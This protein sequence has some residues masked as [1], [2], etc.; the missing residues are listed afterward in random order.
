MERARLSADQR[1]GS[2]GPFRPLTLRPQPFSCSCNLWSG[3]WSCVCGRRIVQ[4]AVGWDSTISV[5][6]IG[7]QMTSPAQY[8]SIL[9][10][11]HFCST[12]LIVGPRLWLSIKGIFWARSS[13]RWPYSV[14]ASEDISPLA[15][16]QE[17]EVIVSIAFWISSP[18]F[19]R[20]F[21]TVCPVF[22]G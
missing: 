22:F 12:N 15:G 8:G 21:F 5:D 18:R 3:K 16:F 7:L 10:R 13:E 11:L 17:R 20:I 19:L 1:W 6:S 4:N 9:M 14:D 2:V